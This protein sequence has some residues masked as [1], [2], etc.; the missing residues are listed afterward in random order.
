MHILR[1]SGTRKNLLPR[2][3]G[4]NNETKDH[5]ESFIAD[6]KEDDLDDIVGEKAPSKVDMKRY[7]KDLLVDDSLRTEDGDISKDLGGLHHEISFN[8]RRAAD[9]II[10]DKKLQ[11]ANAEPSL[12]LKEAKAKN[13]KIKQG[14]PLIMRDPRFKTRNFIYDVDELRKELDALE[15]AIKNADN[16]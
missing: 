16:E 15:V 12:V 10:D 1:A 14:L 9:N 13:V 4:E 6:E 8:A 5:L 3:G 2:L 7:L 11:S